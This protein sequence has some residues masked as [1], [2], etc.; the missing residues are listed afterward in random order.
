PA[1]HYPSKN[2]ISLTILLKTFVIILQVCKNGDPVHTGI[3]G[4]ETAEICDRA[5]LERQGIITRRA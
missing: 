5:V 1:P 4:S 2:P 3:S